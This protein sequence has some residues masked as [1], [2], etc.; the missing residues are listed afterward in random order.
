MKANLLFPNK[1]KLIGWILLVPAALL[2]YFVIFHDFEFSFLDISVLS[3]FPGKF[4]AT[5]GIPSAETSVF[6][7]ITKNNLTNEIV[8]ILFIVA[9][10]FVAFAKEKHEDEYIAK[11]R[12]DSL[13][14]ATYATY[15]IL[16]F[17]LLFIYDFSFLY[18]MVI[19]MFTLLIVFIFRFNYLLLK[20]KRQNNEK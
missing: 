20:I 18:V 16:L 8:G 15:G 7:A 19:N 14:W 11:I 2:G 4:N 13:L 12:L 9:A 6:W 10:L 1:F 5:P 3:L 17:S